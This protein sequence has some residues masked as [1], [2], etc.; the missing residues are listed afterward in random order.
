MFGSSKS[1]QEVTQEDLDM[2]RIKLEDIDS[3]E[4]KTFLLEKLY[5]YIRGID[6]ELKSIDRG[7]DSAEAEERRAELLHL[8]D[9]AQDIRKQIISHQLPSGHYGL[10]IEYPKG[11][12]G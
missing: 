11:Y 9:D 5:R 1:E 12:E 3:T 7:S 6:N 4:D 8:K 2:I 10:F